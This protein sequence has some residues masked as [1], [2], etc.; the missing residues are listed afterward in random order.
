MSIFHGSIKNTSHKIQ[1]IAKILKQPRNKE[2]IQDNTTQQQKVI[3]VE[4]TTTRSSHVGTLL[5]VRIVS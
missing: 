4:K 2:Q 5:Y 3:L 1:Q